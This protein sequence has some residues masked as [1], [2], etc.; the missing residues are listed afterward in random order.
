MNN[1]LMEENAAVRAEKQVRD[2]EIRG[3]A[4]DQ[5]L[6]PGVQDFNHINTFSQLIKVAVNMSIIDR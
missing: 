6:I 3:E 2:Q 4:C 5:Y 1:A